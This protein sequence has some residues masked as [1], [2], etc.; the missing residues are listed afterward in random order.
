[1]ATIV[2]KHVRQLGRHLGL[3]D[4]CYLRKTAENFKL[5]ENMCL[6]SQ[7]GI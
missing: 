1:M 7:V 4:K 6:K 2:S 5:V 3:F